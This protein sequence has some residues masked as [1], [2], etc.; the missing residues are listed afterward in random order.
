MVDSNLFQVQT[1]RIDGSSGLKLEKISCHW[2]VLLDHSH[3]IGQKKG[4]DGF[5]I[6]E[7][8]ADQELF[9]NNVVLDCVNDG[10][11]ESGFLFEEAFVGGVE[12]SWDGALLFGPIADSE[13]MGNSI[14]FGEDFMEVSVTQ[15]LFVE[16][17]DLCDHQ[18]AI[19]D[20]AKFWLVSA[21]D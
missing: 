12:I 13:L 4:L 6:I 14:G 18:V 11:D 2:G 10:D 17:A 1:A 3:G 15:L 19:D 8:E 21:D 7:F 20:L 5:C 16:A 9:F